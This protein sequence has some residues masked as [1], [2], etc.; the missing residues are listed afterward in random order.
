MRG[1]KGYR[2]GSQGEEEGREREERSG[3]ERRGRE[4]EIND[5]VK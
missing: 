2:E 1:K 3:G 4:G 5:P